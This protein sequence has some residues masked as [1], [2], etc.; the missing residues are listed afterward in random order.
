MRLTVSASL[1]IAAA[2]MLGCAGSGPTDLTA[3]QRLEQ[4]L[5]G[6]WAE[7]VPP[8][9]GQIVMDLSVT[10]SVISGTG[11]YT[12]EAGRSGTLVVTGKIRGAN[13]DMSLTFDDNSVYDFNAT[14]DLSHRLTGAY[15]LA[16]PGVDPI[17]KSFT[18]I[19]L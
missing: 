19:T 5:P 14:I 1:V 7:V 13:A 18:K 4:Q 10:D 15:W 12:V 3:E 9:S 8:M 17:M 16:Q 2:A 11:Q 6:R